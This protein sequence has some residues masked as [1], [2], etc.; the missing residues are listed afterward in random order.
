[1]GNTAY[2]LW[3]TDPTR[4]NSRLL[5]PL[6]TRFLQILDGS[7]SC[8]S[9]LRYA[10]RCEASDR[11]PGTLLVR[12]ARERF[13][14]KIFSASQPDTPPCPTSSNARDVPGIAVPT[15][16]SLLKNGTFSVSPNITV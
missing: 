3:H 7:L 9:H 5:T 12:P 6:H 15:R 8:P 4:I 14:V 11:S 2:L 13:R 1:M 10:G 16:S